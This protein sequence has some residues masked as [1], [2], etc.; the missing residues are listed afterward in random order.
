MLE[1]VRRAR[2]TGLGGEGAFVGTWRFDEHPWLL[3]PIIIV[4]RKHGHS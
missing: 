1:D 4:G 2:G 3:V